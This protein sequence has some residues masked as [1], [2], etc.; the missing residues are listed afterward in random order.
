MA[1]VSARAASVRRAAAS[2]GS[3]VAFGFPASPTSS[4]V[5]SI[6]EAAG[7]GTVV[8][9]MTCA[10]HAESITAIAPSRKSRVRGVRGMRDETGDWWACEFD[11]ADSDPQPPCRA[12]ADLAHTMSGLYGRLVVFAMWGG[13]VGR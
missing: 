1:A 8:G 10:A 7:R 3:P 4:T 11:P 9:G 13:A 12:R 6:S 2:T 5:A